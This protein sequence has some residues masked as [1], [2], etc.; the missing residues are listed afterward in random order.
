MS[1]LQEIGSWDIVPD[2]VMR[3]EIDRLDVISLGAMNHHGLFEG[4]HTIAM[5][6]PP[7]KFTDTVSHLLQSIIG[8]SRPGRQRSAV[9]WTTNSKHRLKIEDPLLVQEKTT[10][11]V[12]ADIHLLH[13]LS[14]MNISWKSYMLMQMNKKALLEDALN[15]HVGRYLNSLKKAD[16]YRYYSKA[17]K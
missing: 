16:V 13:H 11:D 14:E 17:I 8:L 5:W 3:G 10:E 9:L 2:D 15:P 7:H 6:W 12:L 1:W 4:S